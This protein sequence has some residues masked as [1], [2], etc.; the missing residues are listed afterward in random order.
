MNQQGNRCASCGAP[1]AARGRACPRCGQRPLS[2]DLGWIFFLGVLLLGIG[3]A[4][5]LISLNGLRTSAVPAAVD[6]GSRA[7]SP[8]P[9]ARA[10]P[11]PA[12]AGRGKPKSSVQHPPDPSEAYVASDTRMDEE[13]AQ[14]V[15]VALC[16]R[17]DTET[18]RKLLEEPGHRDLDGIAAEACAA[19]AAS[20]SEGAIFI[21]PRQV[22]PSDSSP[23]P[24]QP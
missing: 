6:Q 12:V 15:S 9:T 1:M 18:I 19:A 11:S 24:T 16:P 22:L 13:V 14:V 2:G 20:E 5:G 7:S 10:A 17:P 23:A 21:T 3:L 4:S 8:V